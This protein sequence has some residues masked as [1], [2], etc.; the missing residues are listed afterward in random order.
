MANGGGGCCHGEAGCT[1]CIRNQRS[2]SQ[3]NFDPPDGVKNIL[4]GRFPL[5]STVL[6]TPRCSFREKKTFFFYRERDDKNR[7]ARDM[8]TCIYIEPG[9]RLIKFLGMNRR[10]KVD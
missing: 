5:P 10:K 9:I 4:L 2:N 3:F 1:K 7:E 6:F 8:Y